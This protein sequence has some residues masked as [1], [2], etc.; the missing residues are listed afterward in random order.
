MSQSSDQEAPPDLPSPPAQGEEIG[1]APPPPLP[2]RGEGLAEAPPPPASSEPPPSALGEPGAAPPALSELG[3]A[4]PAMGEPGAAPPALSELGAAPSSTAGGFV[5]PPPPFPPSP[6]GEFRPVPPP[7]AAL[8]PEAIVARARRRRWRLPRPWRQVRP[9]DLAVLMRGTAFL[10]VTGFCIAAFV[11][12]LTGSFRTRALLNL[13]DFVNHNQLATRARMQMLGWLA[14]G[15]AAGG[16]VALALFL[17]RPRRRTASARAARVLRAGRLLWPL[18][19]P[20]LAWPLLVANEWDAL[21][22]ISGIAF[23][24]LLSEVCVRASASEMITGRL[25][26]ARGLARVGGAVGRWF[27]RARRFVSPATVVVLL[28]TAFYAVWMS[29]GTILQHRQFGTAAFDLGNYDTMFFNALHGHPFRCPSVFPKGPNWSMLSTHA[30]LTMFALLPFYALHPNAETLLVLQAVALAS[31]A[32]PLYR[33]ASRRLPATAAVVL[34]LAYLL[35]APMHEANFY[36]VHFQ[37][38]AVPFTL[39]ALDMLDARRPVLFSLFFVLALGCR[40]DVPIGFAVC[41]VYLLLVGR[42]TRAALIMTVVAVAYFV[43][44]KF[45]VMPRFGT[46]WFSDLYKDLYPTGENTYGGVV[47]TLLTNPI[48]VW[49]TLITTEKIVLFLLVAVPIVFL[50]LRR[51]LLWMSLLPAVPFTVLTTGYG[52]TVEISFQYILL[53]IPFMFLAAA[54]ALAAYRGTPQGRARLA[55][56]IGGIA[57]ATFLTTRVWGAMPPGDKFRGGFRDIPEFRPLSAADKQKGRDIAELLAKV[58][59]TAVLAASEMEHPHVSARLD[60]LA[61]RSGYDGAD[62]ILYGEDSGGGGADAANRALASGEYELVERRPASRV[63]L[64]RKKKK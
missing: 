14:A 37:K 35:Y 12:Q 60:C 16:L 55:G 46:W 20:A 40:E 50:P 25:A 33:F 32:I 28:G 49:K 64:L 15:S 8:E 52:P 47:K 38:F 54:L 2:A 7:D 57:M 10:V 3:A 23:V 13:R 45:V 26:L 39:W 56:A 59:K 29:Y 27:S 30:E 34:A 6:S 48:F 43:V 1:E 31:G 22:R 41:G 63:A 11:M 44:I 19:L 51:G 4:P 24:A 58:P 21:S 18:M 9:R 17:W 53:Y 5:E 62:Y 36:D 61:L 42:H